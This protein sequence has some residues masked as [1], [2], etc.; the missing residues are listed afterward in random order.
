MRHFKKAH[1]ILAGV[2]YPPYPC[3]PDVFP[4]NDIFQFPDPKKENAIA[5]STFTYRRRMASV[6]H[7]VSELT[8]VKTELQIQK[9][10]TQLSLWK[11]QTSPV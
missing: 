9:T 10:K 5:V 4:P 2:A 11:T 3:Y 8:P 6:R 7:P 1:R